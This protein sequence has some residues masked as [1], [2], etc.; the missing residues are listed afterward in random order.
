MVSTTHL[1]HGLLRT[2]YFRLVKKTTLCL[3]GVALLV[4]AAAAQTPIQPQP[5]PQAADAP[6]TQPVIYPTPPAPPPTPPTPTA[7]PM[8]ARMAAMSVQGLPTAGGETPTQFTV[9]NGGAATYTI[10]LWTA[11]GVGQVQPK[12]ALVYNSRVGDGVFGVGW[13][14]SGL[15]TISRCNKTYAQD[16]FP[17]AVTLTSSDRFCLDGQQLKLTSA[18][19]TYGQPNSTYATEIESFSRIVAGSG[20]AGNG[21]DSFIVTTKNG[22]IYEYGTYQ[23]T[24]Y[25]Q[26]FSGSTVRVWALSRIRDRVGNY[27]NFIYSQSNGS[28]TLAEIDYP[29]TKSG[30]GPFYRVQF[31]YGARPANNQLSGY[32]AGNQVLQTQQ[33]NTITMQW[34]NGG[35][36][37][38]TKTYTLT[39]TQNAV[40]N[41]LQLTAVQECSTSNCFAPTQIGYQ[42]GQAG[43]GSANTLFSGTA[44][45][46]VRAVFDFDGSGTTDLAWYENGTW[47]VAFATP[48]GYSSPVNTGISYQYPLIDS[49]DA[50]GT[51]GFLV[52]QS[53]YWWLYKWNGSAFAGVNTNVS[54]GATGNC[55]LADVDGDGR[56]DLVT[57]ES[58][59]YLYVRLNTSAGGSVSFSATPIKTIAFGAGLLYSSWGS[60]R[61]DFSGSG[62]QDIFQM[63]VHFSGYL[64]SQTYVS[65]NVLHFTGSTFTVT[66]IGSNFTSMPV[67]VADY[68]DDGCSDVL[69]P[70]ALVI[71]ACNGAVATTWSFPGTALFGMDWNGDKL[72]DVVVNNGG[73][74]GIY[75]STGAGINS[76]VLATTIPYS[77]S[78]GYTTIANATGDGLDALAVVGGT[79][80]YAVQYYLHQGN[81]TPPDLATSFTDG[82]GMNQSPTYVSIAQSDYQKYSDASYPEQDYKGPLYVASQFTASDG[83]GSTYQKQFY[84]YAG[85]VQLQGRGFEGFLAQRIYDTRNSLYTYDYVDRV[86]PFNGMFTQHGTYQSNNVTPM[87]VWTSSPASVVSGGSGYEQRYFP[88]LTATQQLQYEYGGSLNGTLT[89]TAATSYT[90]GDGYGNATKV[91]TSTTDND[92]GSPYVGSIWRTTATTTFNNDSS[93]NWCL[94]LPTLVSLQNDVPGQASQTRTTSYGVDSP[95]CRT[96]QQI[97]EPGPSALTVETDLGFDTCGNV[98]SV[99][100]TGHN[101]DGSAMPVRTTSINYSYFTSRCQFPEAVTDALS[102]TSTT[103]YQADFGVPLQTTDPNGVA[104]S[105][106]YDDFGRQ[107]TFK[108]GDG[109]QT[110]RVIASCATPPCWGVTDLR[111]RTQD[112]DWGAAGENITSRYR[113]YDGFNRLRA[114]ESYHVL[115]SGSLTDDTIIYYD[116]LGRRIQQYQPWLSSPNG[117]FTWSYDPFSRVTAQ[118]LYQSSGALDRT[119]SF[120]YAGRTTTTTDPLSNVTTRVTD[121]A[122]LLRRVTD[123]SPG[124]ATQFDYD[125]FGNL[126]KTT[127][128]TGKVSSATYNLRGF[129]TQMVD[130][131]QGTWNLSGDSLNELVAYTDA[132]SKSFGVTYDVLGRMT[133]RSE[134]EGTSYWNWGLSATQHNVGR[135]ASLSGYGYGEV[136]TYDTLGRL[137]DRAITSDTTYHF[138]YT[139][140]S[141]GAVDTVTYPTSTAGVRYQIQ[142]CYFN[143]YPYQIRDLT[144]SGP[145]PCTTAEPL[146]WQLSS[147]NDYSSPTSET[148]GANLISVTS[149]YKAWTN[150]IVSIQSGVS[151]STTNR[152]NLAYQWDTDDNLTQRQDI[153]QSLTE[154]FTPDALRRLSTSA[155]N[156]VQN[157]S[158]TYDASGNITNRSDVGN[159]TYGDPNHPHA[160]TAAGSNTYTYDANGN[161]ATRNGVTLSWASFNQPT[162]LQAVVGGSSLS[163]TFSYG[164][165]HQRYKQVATYL[166]GSETTYYVRGGVPGKDGLLLEKFSTTS[167]GLTYYR[168]YVRT[169]SG[170]TLIVS[171]NS[172]GST[173]A[174]YALKDHLGGTDAVLDGGGTLKVRESF[175]AFGARRAGNTWS[176]SPSGADASTIAS[177]TRHG[178]TGHEMLDNIGLVNMNGRVYDPGVGRFLSVDPLVSDPTNSQGYNPYSYVGNSPLTHIDPS[179]Y[180]EDEP[181]NYGGDSSDDDPGDNGAGQFDGWQPCSDPLCTQT[182]VGSRLSPL[183]WSNQF[184]LLGISILTERL[185][186]AGIS[187]PGPLQ[188][189]K[190]QREADAEA[191]ASQ[192]DHTA[193]NAATIVTGTVSGALAGKSWVGAAT[194]LIGGV[195]VTQVADAT[196]TESIVTQFTNAIEGVAI[197]REYSGAAESVVTDTATSDWESSSHPALR[198]IGGSAIGGAVVGAIFGAI[199]GGW[200]GGLAGG[201]TGGRSGAIAGAT[202][203][204]T[205]AATWNLTYSRCMA[206][207]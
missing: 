139:Y 54:N 2:G 92:P 154:T 130:A 23:S 136:L 176:G 69:T 36:W 12:L 112:T 117:Y 187:F 118:R 38:T 7:S 171:R 93:S 108:R 129:K 72:R 100:V 183:S 200:R 152:Q 24:T 123:P 114:D 68:N 50:S 205:Y 51:D 94:G 180:A 127:D 11:P 167:T 125:A 30:Q 85:R 146:I 19:G 186:A 29:Y 48:T 98:S 109:T 185:A 156:G 37:T 44:S 61:A 35:S 74:L 169:P 148:L 122:G 179:G 190:Q 101:P 26:I 14:L 3:F 62:Q 6:L 199:E 71:S 42:S 57:V 105:G 197:S 34:S 184:R 28:Y 13:T 106:Q 132:K 77:S 47:Q 110:T 84:Y 163:S 27:I 91:Q 111:L 119:T 55:V 52:S 21:P 76:S 25:S 195:A 155:L 142:Y 149:G 83:T 159:Y 143:G 178:F 107:I 147:A 90:Y 192:A 198:Q 174:T 70:N 46:G 104:T 145:V 20:T 188:Q 43:L 17:A 140:N 193:F 141:V 206:Q 181:H 177:T 102:E 135:L 153:N 165:D 115:N 86:F 53:G 65:L 88:Y 116:S 87:S 203:F 97:T 95:N 78:N 175:A 67:D 75:E 120:G 196:G 113:F 45:Q 162:T 40:S 126:N 202:Y 194:G 4:G 173:S 160:V 15:S 151:G 131:D 31:A 128:A 134:P 10:P 144:S 158:V 124:G 166:N 5:L 9:T 8:Q 89:Q 137:A 96:T 138:D 103:T 168:H 133:S 18:A 59:G 63:S 33:I 161:L 16:G 58:D 1:V 32:V 191:C 164:P 22:L 66:N 80:P 79:A 189:G 201:A 64:N 60:R 182:V 170:L 207:K 82:F 121:V 172:D 39:L 81:G 157:L 49:V 150:E 41:R 204:G 56:P 73:T 99:A